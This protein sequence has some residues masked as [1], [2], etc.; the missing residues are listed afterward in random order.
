MPTTITSILMCKCVNPPN[1][2]QVRGCSCARA[3]VRLRTCIRLCVFISICILTELPGVAR[4][5]KAATGSTYD[6]LQTFQNVLLVCTTYAL[7]YL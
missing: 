2:K 6:Y 1:R 7:Q 4:G 3:G 5:E